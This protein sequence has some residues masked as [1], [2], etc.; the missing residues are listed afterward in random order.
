MV[1]YRRVNVKGGLYFITITLQNRRSNLLTENIMSIRKALKTSIQKYGFRIDS[2]CVLPDHIHM[3]VQ[4][5]ETKDTVGPCIQ[6]F[7]SEFVKLLKH[8]SVV[9]YNQKGEANIWQRR[10]WDHLIRDE[11]DY[12]Q[13]LDYMHYNPI[14]HGLVGSADDW[15]FSSYHK[16]KQVGWYPDNWCKSYKEEDLDLE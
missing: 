5:N 7:K 4:L 13:H 1:N 3:M 6:R 8:S 12:K 16:F 9:I 2:I 11:N 14:K 15:E 10:F